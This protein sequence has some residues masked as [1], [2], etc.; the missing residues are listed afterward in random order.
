[1][2]LAFLPTREPVLVDG[3]A[4]FGVVLLTAPVP[5]G[6]GLLYVPLHWIRPAAMGIKAVTSICVSMGI[7]SGEHLPA[8]RKAPAAL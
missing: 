2:V 3:R 1:M 6:G 5:L 8:A 7:P 4:Y